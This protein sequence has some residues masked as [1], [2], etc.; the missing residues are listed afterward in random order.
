MKYKYIKYI[1]KEFSKEYPTTPSEKFED[2][3]SKASEEDLYRVANAIQRFGV[4]NL[5]YGMIR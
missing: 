4:K 1:V 2:R 5:K 3:L